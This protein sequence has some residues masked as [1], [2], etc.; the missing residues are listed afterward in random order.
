MAFRNRAPN[1]PAK[2]YTPTDVLPPDAMSYAAPNGHS[3]PAPPTAD[4]VS[5]YNYGRTL[6]NTT[7]PLDGAYLD[8][9]SGQGGIFDFQRGNNEFNSNYIY[10]A[11][12][13]IGILM[14][15]AGHSPL[16]GS[17]I[18]AAYKALIAKGRGSAVAREAVQQGYSVAASGAC[19]R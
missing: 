9:A 14:N 5:V 6:S 1:D 19:H 11:N 10:A 7:F 16:L 4:F 13:A 3:F 2:P 15:G 18:V 12:Y 8:L 17:G